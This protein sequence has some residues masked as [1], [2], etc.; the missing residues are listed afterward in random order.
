MRNT[1]KNSCIIL[2]ALFLFSG[3][4]DNT[5]DTPKFGD[6]VNPGLSK[7]KS[8]AEIY[9][10]AINPVSYTHLTLPTKP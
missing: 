6:C 4:V 5:Y 9:L 7:T 10:V 3:C 1:I 2:M 8:I